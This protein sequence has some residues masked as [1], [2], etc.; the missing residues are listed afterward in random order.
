MREGGWTVSN[1]LKGGAWNRK[2]GRGK[3]DFKKGDNLCQGVGALKREGWKP[4]TNYSIEIKFG[5]ILVQLMANISN[6]FLGFLWVPEF[7]STPFC[8]SESGNI[9]WF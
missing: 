8:D 2:E 1:T 9:M 3:K 4:L 6:L 5:E 7:S